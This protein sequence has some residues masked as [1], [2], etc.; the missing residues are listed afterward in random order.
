MADTA[1]NRNNLHSEDGRFTMNKAYFATRKIPYV[2]NKDDEEVKAGKKE[3]AYVN[4]TTEKVAL[5]QAAPR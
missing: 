3:R 4:F 5:H 2:D 1:T